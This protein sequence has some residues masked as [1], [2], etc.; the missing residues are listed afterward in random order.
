MVGIGLG[1]FN[2]LDSQKEGKHLY[3]SSELL[4]EKICYR[5]THTQKQQQPTVS[6]TLLHI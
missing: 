3:L 4:E 2:T 6:F 1:R 5:I